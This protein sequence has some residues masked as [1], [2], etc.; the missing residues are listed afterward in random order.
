MCPSPALEHL[1]HMF[2]APLEEDVD[3]SIRGL[4]EILPHLVRL[5]LWSEWSTSTVEISEG[6]VVEQDEMGVYLG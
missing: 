2:P 3:D 5:A 1:R 4:V 6:I